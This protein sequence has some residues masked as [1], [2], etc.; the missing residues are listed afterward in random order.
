LANYEEVVELDVLAELAKGSKKY[1][2]RKLFDNSPKLKDIKE[3]AQRQNWKTRIT[4][5]SAILDRYVGSYAPVEAPDVRFRIERENNE[6]QVVN[7]G[8]PIAHLFP[9]TETLFRIKPDRGQVSFTV[10]EKGSVT[11][12]TLHRQRDMHATRVGD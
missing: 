5:D 1:P 8:Q 9:E 2:M 10:D 12:I 11:G 7:P 3:G 6:L 4:L